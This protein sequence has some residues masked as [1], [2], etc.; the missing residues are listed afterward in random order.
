VDALAQVGATT[1]PRRSH[2]CKHDATNAIARELTAGVAIWKLRRVHEADVS[3]SHRS[4]M[5]PGMS[6]TVALWCGCRVYVSSNPATGLAHTRI[7]EVPGPR[8]PIKRHETGAR[9]WLWE[10][11]PDRTAEPTAIECS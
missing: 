7:V 1:G 2:R 5:L 8:C 4:A 3:L 6:Y 10:M 11:L 9:L